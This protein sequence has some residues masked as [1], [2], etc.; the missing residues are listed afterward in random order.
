MCSEAVV[1]LIVNYFEIIVEHTLTHPK[2]Q[3]QKVAINAQL[4][5][6]LLKKPIATI[7]PAVKMHKN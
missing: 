2:T 4:I 3:F 1:G 6:I 7:I 5:Q